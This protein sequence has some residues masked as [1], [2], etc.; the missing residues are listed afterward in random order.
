MPARARRT[1]GSSRPASLPGRLR[2]TAARLR[3]VETVRVA[4]MLVVDRRPAALP[5][6]RHRPSVPGKRSSAAAG[7]VRCD[8]IPPAPNTLRAGRSVGG[9]EGVETC[10]HVSDDSQ[11]LFPLHTLATEKP[12]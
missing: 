10:P 2:R 8:T 12:P 5:A 6:G 11:D 7:H 9:K 3:F 4:A 1:A